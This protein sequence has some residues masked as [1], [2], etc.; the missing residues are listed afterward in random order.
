ML[1]DIFATKGAEYLL[2]IAYFILLIALVKVIAPPVVTRGAPRSRRPLAEPVP[3]FSLAD[4]YHFHQ[5][6]A[7]ANPA[8]GDLVTVGLDD[9]AAQLVG[10]PDGLELP[11]VGGIVRQG[12]PG[13][14]AESR[15]R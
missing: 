12:E 8:D 13:C 10:P 6:H 1:G 5:G 7:W 14:D 11:A 9:F 15:G 4:G 3:W 2:V